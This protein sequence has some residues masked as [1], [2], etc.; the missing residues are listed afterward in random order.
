MLYRVRRLFLFIR[1]ESPSRLE[2][3]DSSNST[4]YHKSSF[5]WSLAHHANAVEADGIKPIQPIKQP[6]AILPVKRQCA[7]SNKHTV[8][9]LPNMIIRDHIHILI[10][11]LLEL[12]LFDDGKIDTRLP[13]CQELLPSLFKVG[14]HLALRIVLAADVHDGDILAHL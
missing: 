13:V 10:A 4:T 3:Q 2:R 9:R 11:I 5:S 8:A 14:G 6:S 12:R 7:E 1:I